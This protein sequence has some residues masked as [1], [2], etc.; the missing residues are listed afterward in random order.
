MTRFSKLK[1]IYSTSSGFLDVFFHIG[2]Q[3]L[4]LPLWFRRLFAKTGMHKHWFAGYYGG[5]IL[6]VLDRCSDE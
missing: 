5:G 3:G 2:Y 1:L 6:G 4:L